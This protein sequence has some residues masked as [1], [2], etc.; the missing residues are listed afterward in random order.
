[1]QPLSGILGRLDLDQMAG[2]EILDPEAGPDLVNTLLLQLTTLDGS[3]VIGQY[4]GDL[5]GYDYFDLHLCK[6]VTAAPLTG[7]VYW[8]L[9]M[10]LTAAQT[11]GVEES[12]GIYDLKLTDAT[13]GAVNLP[14][15]GEVTFIKDITQ[16]DRSF[17]DDISSAA[18]I[19]EL[20]E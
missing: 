6:T 1:M 14:M 2:L 10:R 12:T 4:N 13:D 18:T 19:L 8:Q 7:V 11:V 17:E 3:I 15:W 20:A 16:P 5:P 9:T